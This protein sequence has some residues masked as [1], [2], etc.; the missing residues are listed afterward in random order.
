MND[1][2]ERI[3]AR[4]NLKR[5]VTPT[6]RMLAPPTQQRAGPSLLNGL[7]PPFRRL[8]HSFDEAEPE[9]PVWSP[10]RPYLEFDDVDYEQEENTEPEP[11]GKSETLR[12]FVL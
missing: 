4:N 5:P 11:Q 6:A 7:L 8:V 9:R 10:C 3:I 12:K 1:V 2:I